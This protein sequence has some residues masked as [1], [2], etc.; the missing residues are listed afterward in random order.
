MDLIVLGITFTIIAVVTLIMLF[1]EAKT[2]IG[3]HSKS[4]ENPDK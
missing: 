4:N 2:F 1:S 3:L